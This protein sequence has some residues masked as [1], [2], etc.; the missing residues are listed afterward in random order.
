VYPQVAGMG[1]LRP[2]EEERIE[3]R[4]VRPAQLRLEAF[5][6]MGTARMGG[7]PAT[8]V[9]SPSG[10]SHGVP[11][12]FVADASVLPTSLGANPMLTIMAVARRTARGIAERLG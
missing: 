4:G 3:A 2:G 10:E 1:I 6:P 12:L 7:D 8:S 11:G 5:H 9:V